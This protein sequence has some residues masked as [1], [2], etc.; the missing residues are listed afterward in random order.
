ML[1]SMQI[2]KIQSS[3][4]RFSQILMCHYMLRACSLIR[5]LCCS[6][7]CHGSLARPLAL[8]RS[9]SDLLEVVLAFAQC[10]HHINR[11]R[12]A[13]DLLH[14]GILT[15]I[16][17]DEDSQPWS[18]TYACP[19]EW[20]VLLSNKRASVSEIQVFPWA[21]SKHIPSHPQS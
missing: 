1:D 7:L 2:M 4:L 16:S 9:G 10:C 17:N 20:V 11:I 13:G 14:L 5:A 15:P 6:A 18:M 8:T 21:T 12:L 3:P 19:H